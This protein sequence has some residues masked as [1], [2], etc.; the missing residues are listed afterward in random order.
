MHDADFGCTGLGDGGNATAAACIERRGRCRIERR[1]VGS[2]RVADRWQVLRNDVLLAIGRRAWWRRGAS[3]C[4]T[5]IRAPD[6]IVVVASCVAG[7]GTIHAAF[8][9]LV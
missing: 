3:R 1:R 7:H 9:E 2:Y 4:A 8:L 6:D 5:A